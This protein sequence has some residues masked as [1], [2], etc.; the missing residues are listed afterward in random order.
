MEDLREFCVRYFIGSFRP[1][2]LQTYFLF[3]FSCPPLVV[4]LQVSYFVVVAVS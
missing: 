4:F 3:A 1:P 2:S